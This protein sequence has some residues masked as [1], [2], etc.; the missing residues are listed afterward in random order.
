MVWERQLR[1]PISFIA[2][3]ENLYNTISV[4]R[5]RL[6]S[7]L[8]SEVVQS[9]VHTELIVCLGHAALEPLANLGVGQLEELLHR[10]LAV[11]CCDVS[12]H[13]PNAGSTYRP[14]AYHHNR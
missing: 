9:I 14:E 2:D 8:V 12:Q 1:G 10:L 5:L 7:Y 13:A 11:L 6:R 3:F 4:V